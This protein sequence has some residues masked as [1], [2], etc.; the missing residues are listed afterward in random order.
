MDKDKET[1]TVKEALRQRYTY[2]ER[3]ADKRHIDKEGQRQRDTYRQRGTKT[4]IYTD[5]ETL[6][7]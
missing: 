6:R 7:Q 5:K 2:T 3:H 4:K 1:H